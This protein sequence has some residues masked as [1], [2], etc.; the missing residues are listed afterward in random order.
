MKKWAKD[1]NRHFTQRK[2]KWLIN[3][4]SNLG[5]LSEND[6]EIHFTPTKWAKIDVGQNQELVGV[7]EGGWAHTAGE[8]SVL[9]PSLGQ[10]VCYC[11]ER[12]KPQHQP[13]AIAFLGINPGAPGA[14]WEFHSGPVQ[15]ASERKHPCVHRYVGRG[16]FV[17]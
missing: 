16:P 10:T 15:I 1:M 3:V 12:S 4:I 14:V 2:S 8:A 13:P 7:E 9:P 6:G 5:N 11:P 17:P